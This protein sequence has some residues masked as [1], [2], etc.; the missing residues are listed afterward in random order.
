MKVLHIITSMNSGGAENVLFRIVNSDKNNCHSI[1]SLTHNDFFFNKYAKIGINVKVIFQN[2]FSLLSWPAR[3]IFHIIKF[4]PDVVQTWMF[5]SNLVGGIFS[6]IAGVKKI[7]WNVR[8]PYNKKLYSAQTNIV[9]LL[10]NLFSRVIP[11]KIIYNSNYALETLNF[12]V[13]KNNTKSTVIHNGFDVVSDPFLFRRNEQIKDNIFTIGMAARYDSFKDH[14]TL[15]KSLHILKKNNIPFKCLLAGSE[16]NY[17]NNDLMQDIIK[18]NLDKDIVLLDELNNLNKFMKLIDVNVLSSN[19]ESFPNVIGEA[20]SK[21]IPCIATD[22]GD[23]G[24]LIADTGWLV[25]KSDPGMMSDSLRDAFN[26]WSA[27]NDI[28]SNRQIS[29]YE[30]IKVNFNQDKMLSSFHKI[31]SS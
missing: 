12:G 18:M 23:T 4:K 1:I 11:D 6:K 27:G 9:I 5:H 8:G 7:I 17:K 20:M 30:R 25:K 19:D 28:W 29:S 31:W 22:V 16:I 10:C 24:F 2:K 3:L 26:E 13:N 21:G 14:K 15:L